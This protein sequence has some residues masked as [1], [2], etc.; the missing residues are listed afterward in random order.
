MSRRARVILW[1]R[2]PP[3]DPSGLERAYHEIS[4]KLAGWPGLIGNELLRSVQRPDRFAILSEWESLSA[5]RA[6]ERDPDHPARTAQL[7][8]YQDHDRAVGHYEVY[9][10][11]ASY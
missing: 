9:E 2:T 5:F 8:P 11:T 10:V 3:G 6:W 1:Y 4:Q 7:R